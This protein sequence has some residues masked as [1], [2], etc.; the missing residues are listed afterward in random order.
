MVAASA[1][2]VRKPSSDSFAVK[3]AFQPAPVIH[4]F[5]ALIAARA[6]VRPCDSVND[7]AE[8]VAGANTDADLTSVCQLPILK[9]VDRIHSNVIVHEVSYVRLPHDLAVSV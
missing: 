1:G 2:F 4:L 3:P 9:N 7:H 8:H 6:W 5:D